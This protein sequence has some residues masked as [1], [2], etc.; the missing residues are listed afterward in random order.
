MLLTPEFLGNKIEDEVRTPKRVQLIVDF[1]EPT[2]GSVLTR[3]IV[4][5]LNWG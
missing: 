5:Q 1:I 2:S 3:K 4:P